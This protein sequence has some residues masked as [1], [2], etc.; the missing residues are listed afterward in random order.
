MAEVWQK[1]VLDGSDDIVKA[2]NSQALIPRYVEARQSARNPDK[3]EVYTSN[4]SGQDAGLPRTYFFE[5][6]AVQFAQGLLAEFA[7]EPCPAPDTS[8][9]RKL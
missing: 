4:V 7:A 8:K 6:G 5:P 3:A 2:L 9:L 1:V